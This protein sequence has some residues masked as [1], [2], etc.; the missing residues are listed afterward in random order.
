MKIRLLKIDMYG[1]NGR[2]LHPRADDQG[3]MGSVV[4]AF[5]DHGGHEDGDGD[6]CDPLIFYTVLLDGEEG[7]HIEVAEYECTTLSER[8]Y[9][10]ATGATVAHA[11]LVLAR[12]IQKLQAS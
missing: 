2:E 5:V 1:L 8:E 6:I 4:D 12:M 7:R 3:L 10:A 11:G 9:Q